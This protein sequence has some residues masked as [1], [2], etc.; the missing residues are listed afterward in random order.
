MPYNDLGLNFKTAA[1]QLLR[2]FIIGVLDNKK[3]KFFIII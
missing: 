1:L 3:F 2:K